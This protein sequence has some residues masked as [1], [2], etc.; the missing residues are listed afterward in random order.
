MATP[1]EVECQKLAEDY[2]KTME[3]IKQLRNLKDDLKQR[4]VAAMRNHN[5]SELKSQNFK[6]ELE[7]EEDYK[8]KFRKP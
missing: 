4:L 5:L 3:D 2:K 1:G 6:V 8:V 7:Y